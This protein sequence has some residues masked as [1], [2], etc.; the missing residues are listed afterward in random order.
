MPLSLERTQQ[1]GGPISGSTECLNN[2]TIILLNDGVVGGLQVGAQGEVADPITVV[3]LIVIWAD[4]RVYKC[5][6]QPDD[7]LDKALATCA[8]FHV[9]ESV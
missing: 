7:P 5:P 9:L 3:C 2:H 6:I 1:L 4:G 8:S